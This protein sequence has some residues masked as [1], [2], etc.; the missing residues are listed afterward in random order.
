MGWLMDQGSVSTSKILLLFTIKDTRGRCR[1]TP[2]SQG[3]LECHR[4]YLKTGLPMPNGATGGC[5]TAEL[6]RGDPTAGKGRPG[7][8][9]PQARPSGLEFRKGIWRTLTNTARAKNSCG[10]NLFWSDSNV[11]LSGVAP[12]RTLPGRTSPSEPVLIFCCCFPSKNVEGASL[13]A[14]LSAGGGSRGKRESGA[15]SG[16]H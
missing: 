13:L 8:N 10:P 7:R 1:I 16:I 4:F 11:S 15:D 5:N 2:S 6:S 9:H 3:S 14:G 12:T